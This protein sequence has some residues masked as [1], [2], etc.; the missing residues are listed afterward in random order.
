MFEKG[1]IKKWIFNFYIIVLGLSAGSIL[2][3]G[4]FVAPV[5]FVPDPILGKGILSHFQ[6]GLL[7]SRV[8][9]NFNYLLSFTGFFILFFEFKAFFSLD[10]DKISFFIAIV[11]IYCIALFILYYTPYILHAQ[12]Q[13]QTETSGFASMHKGSELDFKILLVT[14]I[15]LIWRRLYKKDVIVNKQA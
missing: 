1:H 6:S 15:A 7:M 11:V 4:I 12:S 5:V 14:I 10:K 13:M 8:F 2:A 9:I 3:L